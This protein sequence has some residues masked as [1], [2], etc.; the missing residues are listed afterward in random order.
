M[1]SPSLVVSDTSPVS[2]KEER[3]IPSVRE[4]LNELKRRA[5]FFLKSELIDAAAAMAGEKP[6]DAKPLKPG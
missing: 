6:A 3:L 1:T 2:A 4:A 5:G